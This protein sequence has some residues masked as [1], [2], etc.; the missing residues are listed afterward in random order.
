M[1]VVA[2]KFMHDR[3]PDLYLGSKR[4]DFG[5]C[6][7]TLQYL[8][9]NSNYEASGMKA[10]RRWRYCGALYATFSL[11]MTSNAHQA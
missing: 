10:N 4:G 1:V 3:H 8:R 11:V 5:W 2:R 9:C 7:T 6:E